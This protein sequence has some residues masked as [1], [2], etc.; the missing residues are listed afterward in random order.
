[1]LTHPIL[2]RLKSD[3]WFT[4]PFSDT[5]ALGEEPSSDPSRTGEGG[6]GGGT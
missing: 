4:V 3:T 2:T 6:W 1:M 5:D